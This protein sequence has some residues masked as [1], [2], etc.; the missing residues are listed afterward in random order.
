MTIK[1]QAFQSR[2]IETKERIDTY[3]FCC[4]DK[5]LRWLLGWDELHQCPKCK[6]KKILK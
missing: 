1:I 3:E 2:G 6:A 4:W 5:L